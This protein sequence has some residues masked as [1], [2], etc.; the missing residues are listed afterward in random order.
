M[1]AVV[2]IRGSMGL[3]RRKREI[4]N[5][6]GLVRPNYVGFYDDS[7]KPV[8]KEVESVVTWG[9]VSGDFPSK[10]EGKRRYKNKNIYKLQPPKG[11]YKSVRLFYPKGDLGYRGKE[12]E[13]LIER[14][15]G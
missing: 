11:G 14:M 12:I 9:E 7:M 6:L 3:D 1:I 13:S 4:L 5:R 10:L 2:R 8:I 15:L